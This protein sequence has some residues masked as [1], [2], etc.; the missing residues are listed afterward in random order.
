MQPLRYVGGK[1]GTDLASSHHLLRLLLQTD[2]F[3]LPGLC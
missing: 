1:G 3:G 2:A